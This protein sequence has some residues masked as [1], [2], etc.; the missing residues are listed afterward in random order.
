LV[1]DIVQCDVLKRT[2]Q[3]SHHTYAAAALLSWVSRCVNW[4]LTHFGAL[5]FMRATGIHAK[6]SHLRGTDIASAGCCRKHQLITYRRARQRCDVIFS[7]RLQLIL[8]VQLAMFV[9]VRVPW[10]L[11][12]TERHVGHRTWQWVD[13]SEI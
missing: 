3:Q 2:S 10:A 1:R 13:I 4:L 6:T 12:T 11:H 8:L 7:W 9:I 5:T